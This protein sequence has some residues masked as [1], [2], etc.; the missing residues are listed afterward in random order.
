MLCEQPS[1]WAG[2]SGWATQESQE[3]SIVTVVKG[4]A[5]HISTLAHSII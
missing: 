2:D 3:N 4:I 1:I 5:S